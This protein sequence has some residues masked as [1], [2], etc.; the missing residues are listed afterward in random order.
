MVIDQ[1][2]ADVLGKLSFIDCV[3]DFAI[4]NLT[5]FDDLHQQPF[6]HF[7]LQGGKLKCVFYV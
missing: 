4:P 2:D 1:L 3:V 5:I 6:I 7:Q